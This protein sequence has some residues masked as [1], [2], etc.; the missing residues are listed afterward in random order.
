MYITQF[1]LTNKKRV[2]LGRGSPPRREEIG[3][4][5]AELAAT[6]TSLSIQAIRSKLYVG[7]RKLERP[8]PGLYFRCKLD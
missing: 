6:G 5:R 2:K 1:S 7:A 4:E 3:Q 8:S